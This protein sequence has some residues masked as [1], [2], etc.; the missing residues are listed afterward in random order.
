MVSTGTLFEKSERDEKKLDAEEIK[1]ITPTGPTIALVL[2]IINLNVKNVSRVSKKTF[3][4][5]PDG[6]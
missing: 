5:C 2:F 1:L 6:I 4:L 3:S